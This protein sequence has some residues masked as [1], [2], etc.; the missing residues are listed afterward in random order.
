[1]CFSF[2]ANPVFLNIS[3]TLADFLQSF[4][5]SP[6]ALFPLLY[7]L[8]VAFAS[9][10]AGLNVETRD[11]LP[12]GGVRRFTTTEKVRLR[13]V[14]EG[15]RISVVDTSTKREDTAKSSY[16]SAAETESSAYETDASDTNGIR[17]RPDWDMETA[18]VYELTISELGQSLDT[19]PISYLA[20]T[21]A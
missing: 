9:L 3:L 19:D 1:M 17:D 4:P 14:V 20:E 7:K 2:A 10:L 13:G 15:T 18:K 21:N 8:D 16:A 5:F 12:D 11:T 6:K